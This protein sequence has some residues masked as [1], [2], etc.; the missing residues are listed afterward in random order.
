MNSEEESE[1]NVRMWLWVRPAG[2]VGVTPVG[3]VR[4]ARGGDR[5]LW[6]E[7]DSWAWPC[8]RGQTCGQEQ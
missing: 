3:G 4:P 5:H 2:G 6:V 7:T 8:G 1:Q